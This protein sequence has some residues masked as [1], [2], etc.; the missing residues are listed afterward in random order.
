MLS[1]NETHTVKEFIDLTCE[2][3]DLSVTWEIDEEDPLKTVLLYNGTPI[4]K[5]NEKYYRPAEVDLLFGD[6]NETRKTI[7]WT[8]KISF[9]QLVKK[10]IE[11]DINLLEK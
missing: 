7:G 11:W 10:M 2:Y 6:S 8:P 9:N 1:S 5:I 3:A 4:V